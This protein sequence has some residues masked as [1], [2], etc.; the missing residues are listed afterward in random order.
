MR[1]RLLTLLISCFTVLSTFAQ[2]WEAVK[3]SKEYLYGEGWGTTVA[4]ADQQ[5]LNDLISKISLQVSG[6]SSQTEEERVDNNGLTAESSFQSVV[7]T[8]SS[9]TLTNTEKVIIKNEPDAHVGRW[10]KRTEVDLIFESR[11]NKIADY[12]TSGLEAEKRG[13]VDVA[14]KYLYWALTL[15]RTLRYPNSYQYDDDEGTTF[16]AITT[17]PR[18]IN[19]IF[20]QLQISVVASRDNVVELAI[21]YKGRPVTSVDYAYFD[22]RDWS[23]LYAAKDGKGILELAPGHS[24][25]SY[26]MKI[27]YEY[28]GEMQQDREV[29]SALAC[30][31]GTSMRNAYKNVANTSTSSS[32]SQKSKTEQGVDISQTFTTIPAALLNMPKETEPSA[33]QQGTMK[34]LTDAISSLNYDSVDALF[35]PYA[36]DIYNRLIKYGSARIVGQ[37]QCTY[38]SAGD[39]LLIRGLQMAFTFKTGAR[40]AFVEEVIFSMNAE[41][42]ID[43][44]SF[45]LGQSTE[46]EILGR[47]VWNE[48]ARFAI[49]NFLENYQT[50]YALKRLDYIETIF[51]DNAVIITGTI[52]H[53]AGSRANDIQQQQL[54]HDIVRYNRQNKDTYLHNLKQSFE[55][56]EFINLRF[57]DCSI[58][59]LSKGGELYGIQ[60]SQEY[61]SSNYG[62]RG[63]LFLLV[64]VNDPE[65]PIIKVRTWQPDRDPDF[66]LYGPEHFQ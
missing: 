37:P 13:K 56:K 52:V 66:G 7:Q 32:R 41:G 16:L 43:N 54:A 21:S 12:I 4:E 11:K 59:H 58:R 5:A 63:F 57:D 40:R 2:S 28:R 62:D 6:H 18:L 25:E 53:V 61:Y 10:M 64:D 55:T 31:K 26:Q 45:G 14:L 44:I 50:A 30:I 34:S 51:D 20:D 39:H 9:A 17:L 1:F 24:P 22:G 15:T 65:N 23:N 60:L 49:M 35:T 29:E 46:A 3:S 27:E 19:E 8:Y 36:R 47:S 42:L 33:T 38:Y 48:K